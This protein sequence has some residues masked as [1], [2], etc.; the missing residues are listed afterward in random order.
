VR[1]LLVDDEGSSN[2]STNRTWYEEDDWY[3]ARELQSVTASDLER[4]QTDCQSNAGCNGITVSEYGECRLHTV[5]RPGASVDGSFYFGPC[6][7][8]RATIL[9]DGVFL[10]KTGTF[11]QCY[12]YRAIPVVV[13]TGTT[14]SLPAGQTTGAPETLVNISIVVISGGVNLDMGDNAAFVQLF[15]DNPAEV[16][17][18]LQSSLG[19]SAGVDPSF[20]VIISVTQQRRLESLGIHPSWSRR[21]TTG[22]V[23]VE[24]EIRVPE[25]SRDSSGSTGIS[26]SASAL[27]ETLTQELETASEQGLLT[28]P[29]SVVPAAAVI[30]PP[31]LSVVY[32]VVT[33]TSTSTTTAAPTTTTTTPGTG[34]T[35]STQGAT[36]TTGATQVTIVNEDNSDENSIVLVS[37]LLGVIVGL[38]ALLC[39][40]VTCTYRKSLWASD[41]EKLKDVPVEDLRSAAVV[42]PAAADDFND[43]PPSSNQV[44]YAQPLALADAAFMEDPWRQT[45]SPRAIPYMQPVQPYLPGAM[46]GSPSGSARGPAPP[47]M[48]RYISAGS[49]IGPPASGPWMQSRQASVHS[50]YAA[51]LPP[52]PV[53]FYND[54][55]MDSGISVPLPALDYPPQRREWVV[56]DPR[57]QYAPPYPAPYPQV[58]FVGPG[59]PVP[60]GS[61]AGTWTPTSPMT[62]SRGGYSTPQQA[63]PE[64]GRSRQSSRPPEEEALS[65]D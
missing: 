21:L 58:A 42:R 45:G 50:I 64:P 11:Y 15:Q 62:P 10:D 17:V 49:S 5:D 13:N 24:Y 6:G 12:T 35:T 52:M 59:G 37:V 54:R 29:A 20:V 16:T 33:T 44:N 39:G 36:T 27:T 48:E 1:R 47:G 32:E 56:P 30:T 46:P 3:N 28:V 38:A 25:T 7:A 22:G 51:E 34:S 40:G 14:S 61:I 4:C 26:L 19:A 53:S 18:T 8:Q 55:S 63:F 57:Q 2:Q 60:Q 65:V 31:T 23:D 43:R 9:A 41:I